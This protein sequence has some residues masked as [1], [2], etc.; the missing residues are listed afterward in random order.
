MTGIEPAAIAGAAAKAVAKATEEDQKEVDLLRKIAE[1]SGAL[2]PAAKALAKRTAV[3][4]QIRLKLWQ[5]L[6]MLFGV[7]R[8]YFANDFEN[9][10]ADRMADVPEEDVMTPKLSIAGPAVQG[11]SFTVEEPD[12]KAMYLNLLAAASDRRTEGNAHPSFAEVIHQLSSEEARLLSAVLRST[13]LP[14]VEIRIGSQTEENPSAQGWVTHETN[15]MQLVNRLGGQ[16]WSNQ[17]AVFVDNWVRLGLVNVDFQTYLSADDSYGWVEDNPVYKFAQ[18]EHDTP[19]VKRVTY[20]KGVLTV[21]PFGRRF[22]QVAVMAS[23]P[24]PE[25]EG[26][27]VSK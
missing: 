10:M 24:E 12:L 18:A 25:P 3:K 22:H 21:T 19:D 11:I 13:N 23:K 14:I 20:A 8:D 26:D 2:E 6:G 16:V 17:H 4:Q 9:E 15:V 27:G 1:E 5:P 7:S